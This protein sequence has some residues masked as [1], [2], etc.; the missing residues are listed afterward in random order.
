MN[1][2]TELTGYNH[3]KKVMLT[4]NDWYLSPELVAAL[5]KKEMRP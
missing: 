1:N 2:C 5:G 3:Y 4:D